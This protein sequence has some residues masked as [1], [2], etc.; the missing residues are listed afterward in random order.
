[1]P[2]KRSVKKRQI[3]QADYKVL[4][5]RVQQHILRKGAEPGASA[6]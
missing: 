1:M 5:G 4:T 6:L 2:L 3:R